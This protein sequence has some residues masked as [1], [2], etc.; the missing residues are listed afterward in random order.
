MGERSTSS[1]VAGIAGTNNGI[2]VAAGTFNPAD[3]I[4]LLQHKVVV[5]QSVTNNVVDDFTVV[6]PST[7]PSDY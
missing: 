1:N 2:T 3:T 4:K 5:K 7:E 6:A